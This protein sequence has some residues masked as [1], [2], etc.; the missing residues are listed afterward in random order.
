MYEIKE[1]D[2]I[3]NKIDKNETNEQRKLCNVTRR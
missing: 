2:I 3:L 1:N